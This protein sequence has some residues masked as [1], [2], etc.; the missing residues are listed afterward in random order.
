MFCE[1]DWKNAAN[2]SKS[3]SDVIKTI[4]GQVLAKCNTKYFIVCEFGK[5]EIKSASKYLLSFEL[6]LDAI[7]VSLKQTNPLLK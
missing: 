7:H 5:Q 3:Y 1:L 6:L 2:N 4:T